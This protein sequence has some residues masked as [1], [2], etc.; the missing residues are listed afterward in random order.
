MD[1]DKDVETGTDEQEHRIGRGTRTNTER[2]S[3]RGTRTDMGTR[4]DIGT[5]TDRLEDEK[6]QRNRDSNRDRVA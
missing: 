3:D 4:T 1:R 2:Q 6:G 5:G